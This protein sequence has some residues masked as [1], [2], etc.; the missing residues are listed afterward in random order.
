MYLWQPGTWPQR[1]ATAPTRP[2][3]EGRGILL[4]GLS[5]VLRVA[6]DGF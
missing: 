2:V 6:D 3:P 1:I 4:L 5:G